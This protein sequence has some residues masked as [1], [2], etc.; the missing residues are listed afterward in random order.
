MNW[1]IKVEKKDLSF[2]HSGHHD[3]CLKCWGLLLPGPYLIFFLGLAEAG[4]GPHV[5][6]D[7]SHPTP[8]PPGPPTG[9]VQAPPHLPQAFGPAQGHGG[10]GVLFLLKCYL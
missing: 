5:G 10:K 3:N 8:P 9:Q 2:I 7:R 6:S 1:Q 4:P